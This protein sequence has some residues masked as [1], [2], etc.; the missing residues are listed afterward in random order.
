MPKGVSVGSVL[1]EGD[2]LMTLAPMNAPVEA[3]IDIASRDVGFVR[4]GDP[5]T[6]KIDAF[7]FAEHGTV[8]G[9]V[10][11]IS[12]DALSTDDNGVPTPAFYRVRVTI[13]AIKLVD[14]P[15]TFRLDSGHDAGRRR[16]GRDAGARR[17][18]RRGDHS[19]RRGGDARAM[20]SVVLAACLSP[21]PDD[22]ARRAARLV[23]RGQVAYAGKRFISALRRW[24]TASSSGSSEAAFRIAELY[25]KGEGVQRN[26]AE[27]VNWYRQAARPRPRHGAAF[28]LGLVL[29]NGALGGGVAKWCEAASARDAELAQKNAQ[30]LF[31]CGFEVKPDPDEALRWLDEAARN[32]VHEADGVVGRGLYRR[33]RASAGFRRRAPAP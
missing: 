17:L 28:R 21:V 24:R 12:E 4:V 27:A 16:E 13:T 20:T 30:A 18:S 15:S 22:P 6:I 3:E 31:P 9:V 11:W 14:V 2:T 32:G 19:R 10:K 29:L 33:A 8:E 23:D 1:K 5:V 7:N 25:V 26:L